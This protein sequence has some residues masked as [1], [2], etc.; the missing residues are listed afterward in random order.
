MED[1]N[2]VDLLLKLSKEQGLLI[3]DERFAQ[4]QDERDPLNWLR[5]EFYVPKISEITENITDCQ[6]TYAIYIL[7]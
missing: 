6:G 5:S 3:T 1:T 7:I 2:C 4:L